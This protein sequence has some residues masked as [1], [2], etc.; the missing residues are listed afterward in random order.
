MKFDIAMACPT[1]IQAFAPYYEAALVC[2]ALHCPHFVSQF[3]PLF[4]KSVLPNFSLRSATSRAWLAAFGLGLGLLTTPAL[5][6][7]PTVYGLGTLSQ[8]IAPGTNPFFPAGAAAGTQGLVT[9][10][11]TTGAAALTMAPML[12]T[13]V[14]AGQTLVGMD[15][16]PNT[17]Q[18][19]ALGYDPTLTTNNARLYV[20]DPATGVA[21]PVGAAA[22]TLALGT[23]PA[24]IGF[25]FNPTV[26]RIRVEGGSGGANY[27]LNPSMGGIAATDGNLNYAAPNAA[28]S[29]LIASVAYTN[30][31]IGSTSTTLYALDAP[32]TASA[33]NGFL[34]VQ[35]PPNNGTLTAPVTTML[36]LYG[37]GDAVA[38]N[39]D[40][41]YNP[42]TGLNEAYLTEVTV[43]N[44]NGVSSS[45]F[46]ALNLTTGMATLRGNTVPASTLTPL[47]IRDIAVV[48]APPTQPA[49]TGQLLYAVAGGNLISFDS[50]N[51][52]V[53]RSAV[54]FGGG[55]TTGQVV[56]GIDFRPANSQ[57]YALGYNAA[58]ATANANIYSVNLTTGALTTV[59]PTPLTLALGATTDRVGFD[60]N[61][62]VDRIRVVSTTGANYRLNPNDGTLVAA[63]GNLTS[64]PRI[65][66]AAYTNSS[67]TSGTSLYD[68]DAAAGQLYLQNPPN[69]G[70]LVA[71]GAASGVT[72]TDGADFDIY[73]AT[74]TTTN[75]AYLAISPGGSP[76]PPSFD[77]L[78]TMDLTTGALTSV[79][80][81]GLGSNVSGLASLTQALLATAPAA[82]S[83]QVGVYPNPTRGAVQLSLPPALGRQATEA[84][85]VN[86]L[87]QTVLRTTLAASTTTQLLALPGVAQGVY[88]L[89]LLTSEGTVNK[90]LVVE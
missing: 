58:L 63:D 31:Y 48:I 76:T 26:D 56:V 75:T 80:R 42:S 90:R 53:V 22:I 61:P 7:T 13:G 83:Q 82:V 10:N 29:P 18:L 51:P 70:T 64:G 30:S 86:T 1:A 66:A 2:N 68:Y 69:D 24:R 33:N 32:G 84:T 14:T 88:M 16:R 9:I 44:T 28:L 39:T 55:I 57:L 20:L 73:N 25:D 17:G 11:P 8:T 5:A 72:S 77:N 54:N 81:I 21:A 36:G 52:T 12:V 6:Q 74:G 41:Y 3:F 85:L 60:F 50:G 35:S 65:S 27:R 19:F 34:S 40:V 78:Y 79:G 47:D 71:V 59:G 67:T 37:I 89:R 15:Y 87:G 23:N 49:L 45:N 38:L 46:Y 43:R 4:M 62:T